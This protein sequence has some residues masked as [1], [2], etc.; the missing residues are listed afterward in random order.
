MTLKTENIV[1]TRKMVEEGGG[2]KG[3]T[4]GKKKGAGQ[5]EVWPTGPAVFKEETILLGVFL[6][7]RD[8]VISKKPEGQLEGKKNKTGRREDNIPAV[9][10]GRTE[11][12]KIKS[13][14][15]GTHRGRG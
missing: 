11:F 9:K 2:R 3:Q 13:G 8:T 5:A 14:V 15:R 10:G 1:G 7:R 6:G 12:L 4:L